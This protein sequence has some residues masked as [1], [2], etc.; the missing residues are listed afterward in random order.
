MGAD[1][2]LC[3]LILHFRM[4]S[5][6]ARIASSSPRAPG[7]EEIAVSAWRLPWTKQESLY[8]VSYCHDQQHFSQKA[9]SPYLECLH[10]HSTGYG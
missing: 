9:P 4:A 10:C 5:T 6:L 8:R 1:A 3:V 7:L 2:V